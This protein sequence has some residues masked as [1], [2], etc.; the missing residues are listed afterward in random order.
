LIFLLCENEEELDPEP[1]DEKREQWSRS[2]P[3]KLKSSG[4]GTQVMFTKWISSGSGVAWLPSPGLKVI[5][6]LIDF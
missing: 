5:L 6:A 2:L 3:R 4:A 1:C